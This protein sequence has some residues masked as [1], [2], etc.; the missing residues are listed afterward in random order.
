MTEETINE[1][2]YPNNKVICPVERAPI[3]IPIPVIELFTPRYLPSK[4]YG[5]LLNKI[6]E[7]EVLKIEKASSIKHAESM[8]TKN[9]LGAIR[10]GIT[11]PAIKIAIILIGKDIAVEVSSP[12]RAI[13]FGT[14]KNMAIMVAVWDMYIRK[15][16]ESENPYVFRN[17]V[18]AVK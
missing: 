6:K 8:A 4:P 2:A 11:K 14:K 12:S 10:T 16:A 1:V 9:E 17:G 15:T 7:F 3:K 5:M 13:I 18:K